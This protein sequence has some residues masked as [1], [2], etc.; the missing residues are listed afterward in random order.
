MVWVCGQTNGSLHGHVVVDCS[1]AGSSSVQSVHCSRRVSSSSRFVAHSYKPSLIFAP[2][3]SMNYV[4]FVFHFWKLHSSQFPCM[5]MFLSIWNTKLNF[6]AKCD[7]TWR[8]A[9]T[10]VHRV[11]ISLW[12][13]ESTLS[14]S[15]W[16]THQFSVSKLFPK[17]DIWGHASYLFLNNKTTIT[18]ASTNHR[19]SPALSSQTFKVHHF[20][21]QHA[22]ALK[23]LFNMSSLHFFTLAFRI[24]LCRL[25]FKHWVCRQ[26]HK[27]IMGPWCS[28]YNIW[29]KRI[30]P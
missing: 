18:N 11:W 19:S 25:W 10:S 30:C 23:I 29:C 5:H 7:E 14:P 27:Y 1:T 16:T 2:F 6:L 8:K 17:V 13:R 3:R 24:H 9:W 15:I 28:I 22:S 26:S 12:R 20:G 4:P 21:S